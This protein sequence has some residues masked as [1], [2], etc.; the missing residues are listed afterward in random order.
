MD[1]ELQGKK[2]TSQVGP[3]LYSKC[4]PNPLDSD[5]EKVS[6]PFSRA[7]PSQWNVPTG[8]WSVLQTVCIP[9][10]LNIEPGA[11]LKFAKDACLIIQG[12]LRAVGTAEARIEL[13][14]EKLGVA[15]LFLTHPLR[16]QCRMSTS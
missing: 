12:T 1:T 16:A 2:F 15:S 8:E 4:L 3:T 11:K 5:A 13:G 6:E 14:P 7:G 9:G 10:D